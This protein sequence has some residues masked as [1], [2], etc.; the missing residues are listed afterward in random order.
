[1][2]N[3]FS[4]CPVLKPQ[5]FDDDGNPLAGG[6]LFSYVAGTSIPFATYVD[7]TGD[8]PNTNPIVLDS[9]GRANVWLGAGSYKFIL[10]DALGDVI[11][12]VDNVSVQ[13]NGSAIGG[14]TSFALLDNQSVYEDV[15]SLLIDHTADQCVLA[16]YTIIRTDGTNYRREHGFLALLYDTQNGWIMTRQSQG[17][18]SLNMGQLS[19][20]ITSLGQ[21][22]YKSDSMGGT[23]NGQ[24]TWQINSAFPAEG[25]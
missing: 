12:T 8:T 7:S 17:A 13:S 5:Y 14:Q 18:D 15:P 3:T 2:S 4:L 1:M 21:V 20:A 19:L 23:Y 25:I 24:M 9:A 10:E 16:E 22:Q 6:M 11:F